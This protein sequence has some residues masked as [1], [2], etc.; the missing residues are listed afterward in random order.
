MSDNNKT[1]IAKYM[2]FYPSFRE[3]IDKLPTPEKRL[4]AFYMFTDY[5]LYGIEPPEDIDLDLMLIFITAKPNMKKFSQDL[6]NGCK[7]GRPRKIISENSK[8]PDKTPD[9]TPVKSKKDK[10]KE[11]EKEIEKDS[12]FTSSF[13]KEGDTLSPPADAGEV[14]PF[15]LIDCQEC[16]DEGKVNLSE[17]GIK[18]FYER[19]QKDGWKIKGKAVNNLLLAMRGFAKNHKRYQKT[20]PEVVE[21]IIEDTIDEEEPLAKEAEKIPPLDPN[22]EEMVMAWLHEEFGEDEEGDMT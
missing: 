6:H 15:T 3:V 10:E 20:I 18:A 5:G 4:A 12:L 19:M 8:T 13:F 22:D 16:A 2:A 7:G 17:N 11:K 9:K 21:P 14:S 1:P